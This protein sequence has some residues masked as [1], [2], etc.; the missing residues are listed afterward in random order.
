MKRDVT[1]YP[2]IWRVVDQDA[3]RAWAT[4]VLN[5]LTSEA[6]SDKVRK[7]RSERFHNALAEIRKGNR[8]LKER[9]P[10]EAEKVPI[11][12]LGEITIFSASLG[13]EEAEDVERIVA[14]GDF[15]KREQRNK[16]TPTT[17]RSKKAQEFFPY[18]TN[19][20]VL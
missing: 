15:I 19:S 20:C 13:L 3:A 11:Q 9:Y 12:G 17:E 1:R 10:V 14:V 6:V 2:S 16:T 4:R 5:E 7:E 18:L 8:Y